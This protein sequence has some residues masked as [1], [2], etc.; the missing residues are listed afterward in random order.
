MET[1]TLSIDATE[2]TQ[3]A[4]NLGSIYGMRVN[5]AQNLARKIDKG[6]YDAEKAVKLWRYWFDAAAKN[7]RKEFGCSNALFPPAIRDE[8][9][10]AFSI[11]EYPRIV[12]REYI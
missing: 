12:N 7:Y 8:A 5:I 10:R 1:Q 4:E 9:A 11:A 6:I 2:L 3:W